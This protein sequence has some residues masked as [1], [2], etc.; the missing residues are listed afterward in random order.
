MFYLNSRIKNSINQDSIFQYMRTNFYFL[1][2]LRGLYFCFLMPKLC[3]CS[4]CLWARQVIFLLLAFKIVFFFF[5]QILRFFFVSGPSWDDNQQIAQS[6][7]VNITTTIQNRKQVDQDLNNRQISILTSV[8]DGA[9]KYGEIYII[10]LLFVEFFGFRS[11][12]YL[13]GLYG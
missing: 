10:L 6:C 3:D 8:T 13:H 1:S 2:S 12:F 5:G 7:C 4:F 9:G 11:L